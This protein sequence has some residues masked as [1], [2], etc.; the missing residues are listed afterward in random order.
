[1]GVK[2]KIIFII[3]VVL[4]NICHGQELSSELKTIAESSLECRIRSDEKELPAKSSKLIRISG[5]DG[6]RDYEATIEFDMGKFIY[7]AFFQ[8]EDARYCTLCGESNA[9]ITLAVEKK[10]KK[11]LPKKIADQSYFYSHSQLAVNT[12][13]SIVYKKHTLLCTLKP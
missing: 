9:F 11:L 3:S 4:I 2:V 7:R 8:F 10:R 12:E 5:F 13:Y 6:S 1:M